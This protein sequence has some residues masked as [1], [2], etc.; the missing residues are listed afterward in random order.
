M[1]RKRSIYYELLFFSYFNY[2]GYCPAVI[3][4]TDIQYDYELNQMK[5]FYTSE[6]SDEPEFTFI[7]SDIK[8]Y[9]EPYMND[10]NFKTLIGKTFQ[11]D[12]DIM[13]YDDSEDFHDYDDDRHLGV[14]IISITE[15]KA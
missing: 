5:A 8:K 10:G 4:I 11:L 14:K 1:S 6:L 7:G 13:V 3:T 15:I 2:E 9:F 12:F